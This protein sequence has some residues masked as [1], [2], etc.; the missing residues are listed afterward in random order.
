MHTA[1]RSALHICILFATCSIFGLLPPRSAIAQ[2][3]SNTVADNAGLV[4]VQV[5]QFGAGYGPGGG[6]RPGDWFGIQLQV[7]DRSTG[8]RSLLV[9]LG[10]TDA[11]GDTPVASVPLPPNPD[12]K[13]KVWLYARLPFSR[14]D[15]GAAP[16]EVT[17]WETTN[18]GAADVRD[19]RVDR[20]VGRA[21]LAF[22]G[23]TLVPAT[24]GMFA[25]VTKD[26]SGIV[27]L[28]RYTAHF[29][30]PSPED[31]SPRAHELLA[32]AAIFKPS[33]LPDRWL[34]LYSFEFMVWSSY[35]AGGEPG[36]LS[37]S[38][39]EAITNWVKQG[40]HLIVIVPGAGQVWTNPV[41]NKLFDI[42]PRVTIERR[43]GIDLDLYRNMLM[44]RESKL[45]LPKSGVVSVFTP[46]DDAKPGE[47]MRI[48]SGADERCVVVR[49]LVGSG[50]VTM[51]GFDFTSRPFA[52]NGLPQADVF[53]NRVLGKRGRYDSMAELSRE[54]ADP[55]SKIQFHARS[56]RHFD[57]GIGTL[58]SKGQSAGLGVGL[59]FIC[60]AAYW[61]VAG[62]GAWAFLRHYKL[63]HHAWI[64]FVAATGLF[65]AIAWGGAY[66]IRP[67]TLDGQ[68]LTVLEHVYGQDT[69][70]ARSWITVLLPQYG[71][72][73]LTVGASE[74][75]TRASS[76]IP[77]D[78]P[79]LGAGST[80]FPDAQPYP[81][82]A[83]AAGSVTV[84]TRATVKQFQIDWAGAPIAGWTMP[85]PVIA[86]TP[87]G[88][89]RPGGEI[90]S[91]TKV[92]TEPVN[93]KMY[94]DAQS[95]LEGAIMHNLPGGLRNVQIV[96]VKPQRP[97]NG[98][99]VAGF[100][101]GDAY[102]IELATSDVWKPGEVIDLTSVS[103]QM[104][105][106]ATLDRY[107]ERYLPAEVLDDIVGNQM[108]RGRGDLS[109]M[110]I[111][112]YL[113]VLPPPDLSKANV[114]F[115]R[116]PA[117]GRRR[118]F[119]RL[120]LG[121]WFTQPCVMVLGIA[122]AASKADTLPIPLSVYGGDPLLDR[123]KISGST[124]VRWVYP[125][126]D[127]PPVLQLPETIAPP[128][129]NP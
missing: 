56:H 83:R 67:R 61:L 26:T 91:V 84:P 14:V 19:V 119:H 73:T 100:L 45:A 11:D 114:N 49:R 3:P 31:F 63:T 50:A 94:T 97:L 111:A 120:D 38:Q 110:M 113:P 9:R 124:I 22:G 47:A 21:Y 118:L 106:T 57:R 51:V 77:W 81:V 43:E 58:I 125:L 41:A 74:A 10:I 127:A 64:A 37:E 1:L 68:H 36:D 107:V 103:L 54:E 18:S 15:Q 86:D 116:T 32:P 90:K 95:V 87:E 17:V 16:L 42:T 78:A 82:D 85:R 102:V 65:T 70:R 104:N 2:D 53:W 115:S 128:P 69:D 62:L 122:D 80:S 92:F 117:L 48:L 7:H 75:E 71:K 46:A 4:D 25:L 13:Q 20:R 5:L 88:P 79:G 27:G 8:Q 33:D 35:G 96:W 129:S 93:G 108:N 52:S 126:A 99:P 89:Y 109:A 72:A 112:A 28:D 12:V 55:N 40:G 29:N 123:E 6:I 59:A 98:N 60:Y 39:A 23:G 24:V 30:N 76:I 44:A 101:A 34:G 105:Q 121:R 66:A